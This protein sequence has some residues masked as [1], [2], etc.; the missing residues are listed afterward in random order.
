MLAI[1]HELLLK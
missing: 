1:A